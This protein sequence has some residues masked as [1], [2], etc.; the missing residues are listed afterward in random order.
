M[1]YAFAPKFEVVKEIQPIYSI[2]DLEKETGVY[3]ATPEFVRS[4]CG[5]I[6]CQFLDAVP[7]WYYKKAKTL[8]LF[9]NIDVRI[10]RLYVGNYLS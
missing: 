8:G 1:K 2:E 6:A 5:P 9:P 10:H 3:S 4:N 7:D